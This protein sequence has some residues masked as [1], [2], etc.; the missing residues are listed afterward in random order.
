MAASENSGSVDER[1]DDAF[2]RMERG[3]AGDSSA[4]SGAALAAAFLF[5]LIALG[6]ASYAVFVLMNMEAPAPAPVV[7]DTTAI[8]S[9]MQSIEAQQA[10]IAALEAEVAGLKT[11]ASVEGEDLREVLSS[12]ID[13]LDARMGS[14][15]QD[16]VL[17]EVEYLVR[18]GNQQLLMDRNPGAAVALF[19]EADQ[20]VAG[21]EGLTAH[22]LRE[23]L[24]NDIAALEAVGELD[25]QGLWLRLAALVRQ[26]PSLR[27]PQLTYEQ[28]E[29]DESVAPPAETLAGRAMNL[30]YRGVTRLASLIDFRRDV[31]T[32]API[33]P[34]EES[35]YLR[36]NL[37]LKLQMAQLGLLEEKQQVYNESITDARNWAASHFDGEDA[38]TVAFLEALDALA[39]INVEMQLPDVSESLQQARR[40]VGSR[41]EESGS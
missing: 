7:R 29:P 10:T 23:A 4:G 15:R 28:P 2:E 37:V 20:I 24:A 14:S 8:D 32:V 19:R 36:Q 34:P 9:A 26:V 11:A 16:W 1:L 5:S 38:G 30:L 6:A 3:D 35:Y 21:A 18:M 39:G 31:P 27:E 17:A 12:R 40:L 33:L 22:N 41:L 13:D 25:R